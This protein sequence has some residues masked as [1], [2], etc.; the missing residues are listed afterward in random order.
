MKSF[1]IPGFEL[2][3]IFSAFSTHNRAGEIIFRHISGLT[4]EF[5]IITYTY[6]WSLANRS[7]LTIQWGD[8]T[9]S[10]APMAKGYPII[11]PDDY[12]H[13]VY[14]ATHTFP[15]P[16]IYEVLVQDPNRN[17]GVENIPNSVNV[18]FSIKTTFI[19]NSLIGNNTSPVLLNPPKDK[20]AKGYT[21]IHNP[22]AFDS[23]GDSL[24]YSLTICTG[25]DGL[26]IRNYSYPPASD[27]LYIDAASGDLVWDAPTDTGKFNI[28]M[29]IE[30]WRNGI[31]IGNI[32]RDMQIEVYNTDNNPPVNPESFLKC[33]KAGDSIEFLLTTTDPD[34]DEITQLLNSGTQILPNSPADF[35]L[36]SSEPGT[37]TSKYK[38][39][40]TCDHVRNQPYQLTLKSEDEGDEIIKLVDITNYYIRVIAPAPESVSAT[41]TSTHIDL[42]WNRSFC[43]KA[44]GY[45]IYRR[46]G[47]IELPFDTC[48]NGV[49][50][51]SGF[52]EIARKNNINDTVFMDTEDLVQ[53]IEYCYIVTALFPD[54][55]E[56]Y[57]SD[58][59]C[60][61]LIPGM[62]ALTNVSVLNHSENGEIQVAW[63]RPDIDTLSAPGPYVFQIFRTETLN[64]AMVLIDSMLTSN[65]SDTVYIDTPVN[66]LL[67]PYFYSVRM[68]NN[69]PGNRFPIGEE[70]FTEV[71]SSFYPEIIA[72]DNT[73]R[74][75]FK[76]WVP[77]VNTEY[78]VYRQNSSTGEFDSIAS[79]SLNFYVDSNLNNGTQ[80]CYRIR[81]K[82]WRPVDSLIYTNE[83]ISHINCE[84]PVD[85]VAP[86]P[87]ELTVVSVCDSS[88]NN[89]SWT[90]PNL[91]CA[92]DVIRYNIYYKPTLEGDLDSIA[93]SSPATSTSFIHQLP[94]NVQLSG[95]Y[96][97]TAVDSF[98]N[99]SEKSQRI[100]VDACYL[101]ELPNVFSPNGDGEN[102][103]FMAY[104]RN[105][106]VKQV[107]MKIFNRW[108]QLVYETT[109]P[110][111]R[112][113]G[114]MKNSGK[115]AVS[116]VYYYICDVYEPRLQGIF[117]RNIAGFVHIFAEDAK[118]ASP[119]PE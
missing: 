67:F 98:E 99:E 117:V 23:D 72:D 53:G 40:T 10:V 88:R 2:H 76:K 119:L 100:C 27:T 90:N 86:C 109:D 71:A 33:V 41:A 55:A 54:G 31:K 101:Y 70:E 49:P 60:T 82:G 1:T 114:K 21:Y 6:R 84:I 79:T 115:T 61:S 19:I 108:G 47:S 29:N 113:D 7:E 80:Y 43:S 38:W 57:A 66:T 103:Q 89:L 26:P 118:P 111:F 62:P 44:S 77:W 106:A 9:A 58:P 51:G 42:N 102:D 20:A 75:N 13:N 105:N 74:L 11:L 96:E 17:L 3:F 25:Q 73:L 81:S 28:A 34:G 12:L 92:N 87:P 83:N 91:T 104:N 63:V 68:I 8:N 85:V 35:D 93:S 32:V 65:L 15:G 116:G 95:C 5:T 69:T 97:V 59:V 78:T 56:S 39:K 4:Y 48:T 16:G 112:W 45:A 52:K 50:P 46:E 64:G 94:D 37:S 18:V 22:A 30:E 36:V 110:N 107:N 24:S 14:K